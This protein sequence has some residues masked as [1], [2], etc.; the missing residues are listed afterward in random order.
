M[1]IKIFAKNEKE[2]KKKDLNY[3]NI[4]M[5]FGIEKKMNHAD[6]EKG[7]KETMEETQ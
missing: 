6:N 4:G 7:D 1:N 3:T 5:E 2:Q